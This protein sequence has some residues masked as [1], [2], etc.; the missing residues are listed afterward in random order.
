MERHLIGVRSTPSASTGHARRAAHPPVRHTGRGAGSNV[1]TTRL[2]VVPHRR[3]RI[4]RAGVRHGALHPMHGDRPAGRRGSPTTELGEQERPAV[5]VPQTRRRD[6]SA[7]RSATAT[8]RRPAAPSAGTVGRARRS[9]ARSR[10]RTPAAIGCAAS[11]GST[12]RAGRVRR[13]PP[14]GTA[15]TSSRRRCRRS[16][17]TSRGTTVGQLGDI[18]DGW[19]TANPPRATMPVGLDRRGDLVGTRES[20]RRRRARLEAS[21]ATLADVS[22]GKLVA[23]PNCRHARRDDPRHRPRHRDRESRVVAHIVKV[24]P[25]ESAAAKVL[26]ARINGTPIEALCG[27]VWVPAPR[28]EAAPAVPGVQGDLRAVQGVQRRP[29]RHAGRLSRPRCR[30]EAAAG[31]AGADPRRR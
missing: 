3:E 9:G 12:C 30:A 15:A 5:G 17:P 24:G 19:S 22:G 27:H 26:E 4:D 13:A 6:G 11:G 7:A 18:I 2:V 29:A 25:G 1:P 31:G 23:C 10:H 14:L 8:R 20:R 16:R 28:P 21:R